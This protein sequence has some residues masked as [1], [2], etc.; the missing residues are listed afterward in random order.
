MLR[1]PLVSLRELTRWTCAVRWASIQD[2]VEL[3]IVIGAVLPGEMAGLEDVELAVGQPRVQ[4]LGVARR[5]E[6]VVATGD[7]LNRGPDV[8]E[9]FGEDRQVRRIAA[10]VGR[11]LDKSIA[12]V[13]RQVVLSY[14][15][16]QSCAARCLEGSGDDV[17]SI[18]ARNPR[19]VRGL[20][21]SLSA[22]VTCKRDR[23]AAAADDGAG[24][25]VRVLGCREQHRTSPDVGPDEMRAAKPPFVDRGAAGTCPWPGGTAAQPCVRTGRS[26]ADR[27]RQVA[28]SRPDASRSCPMQTGSRAMD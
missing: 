15:L 8:T 24:E 27:W 22:P 14:G 21:D 16:G 11:R 23:R 2:L 18:D 25:P 26:P 28:R 6:R 3:Q 19:Q 7:D 5:H 10:H 4:E 20:D 13:G 9:S 17:A 12:R 1:R